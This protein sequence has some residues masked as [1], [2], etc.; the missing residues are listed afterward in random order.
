ML[1]IYTRE[2]NG[3]KGCVYTREGDFKQKIPGVPK[4]QDGLACEV[5]SK[6]LLCVG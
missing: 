6:R 2:M 3:S 1:P 4:P 5:S